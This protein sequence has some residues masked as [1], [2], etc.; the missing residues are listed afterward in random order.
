MEAAAIAGK[1]AAA[2]R[3]DRRACRTKA[4]ADCRGAKTS[5][6]H[7]NPAAPETTTVEAAAAVE[8]APAVKPAATE[9]AAGESH[10]RRQRGDRRGRDQGDHYF[11]KHHRTL[12][13]VNSLQRVENILFPTLKSRKGSEQT[14]DRACH[15]CA[16]GR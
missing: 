10:V 7:S 2:K 4:A 5:A 6:A 15:F 11:T 1:A 14:P 13:H 8:A 16:T 3:G 9:A 12:L